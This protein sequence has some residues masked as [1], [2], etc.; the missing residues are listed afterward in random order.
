MFWKSFFIIYYEILSCN[1]LKNVKKFISYL[2]RICLLILRSIEAFQS[3]LEIFPVYS[4]L[5]RGI[6]LNNI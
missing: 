5:L 3:A 1:V 6:G 4:Y 2:S